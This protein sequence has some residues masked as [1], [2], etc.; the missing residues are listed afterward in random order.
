MSKIFVIISGWKRE[1]ADDAERLAV[2]D[3]HAAA[4]SENLHVYATF[5]EVDKL[6]VADGDVALFV[7]LCLVD[8]DKAG[9]GN[10]LADVVALLFLEFAVGL[11]VVAGYCQ[12]HGQYGKRIDDFSHSHVNLAAKLQLFKEYKELMTIVLNYFNKLS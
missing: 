6:L 9:V 10:E 4:L 12:Q 7:K 5:T 8:D 11:I 1:S 3:L 2:L